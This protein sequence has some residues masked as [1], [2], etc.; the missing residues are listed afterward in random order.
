MSEKCKS[1]G[2]EFNSGIWLAPQFSNEKVLLFCSDKCKNEYVKL[3][4]NRIKDNYPGFYDKIMKSLKEGKRDKTIKEELWEMVKSE[5]WR[6][7]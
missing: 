5:E 1:C 6:N 4:L 2:K 3:K 7:E